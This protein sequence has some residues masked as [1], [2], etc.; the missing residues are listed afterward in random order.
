MEAILSKKD[1]SDKTKKV[2]LSIIK[3]LEKLKFKF[4]KSKAEKVDYIK[5]FFLENKMEKASTRLDL[6]NLVI[7]LRTIEELPTDKLKQYRTELGKERLQNQVGK[8]N[9]L[10]DKLISLP[11]FQKELMKAYENGEWKKFIV[12]FF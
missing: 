9:D 11:D 8:M 2:Y 10:K 1:F 3:R 6:L 4:P 7:V 12:N 5:E